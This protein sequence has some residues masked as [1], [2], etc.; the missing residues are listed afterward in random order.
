MGPAMAYV[1]DNDNRRKVDFDGSNAV[2]TACARCSLRPQPAMGDLTDE[3]ERVV[4][5]RLAH[6]AT[7]LND[8]E[9]M[10]R[11]KQPFL[12]S[13]GYM[14]R[15][16]LRPGWIPSWTVTGDVMHA[17][18]C[19]DYQSMPVCTSTERSWCRLMQTRLAHQVQWTPRAC[20]TDDLYA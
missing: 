1:I 8:Q 17:E 2:Q 5:E 10:W 16:R 19:E 13:R 4:V 9:K 14:L 6:S 18:A 12:E 3:E 7:Q 11:D 15:P 20:R